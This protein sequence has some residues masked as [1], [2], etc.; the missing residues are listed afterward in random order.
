MASN[1]NKKI[2][3]VS[4]D[5]LPIQLSLL[6]EAD[7]IARPEYNIGKYAGIIFASPHAKNLDRPREHTWKVAKQ[8]RTI[9]ASLT[10]SPQYGRKTPTTTTLRV[11]LGLIQIWNNNGQPRNGEIEFSARQL[12]TAIGWRWGGRD[13]AKRISEHISILKST[14]ITWVFGFKK[15]DGETMTKISELSILASAEYIERELLE[16]K[17]RFTATQKVMFHPTLVENM[18]EG[19]VRPINHETLKQISNDTVLN[20]YARLDVYL[21]SKPKWK[22]NSYD[23]FYDVLKFQG[24]RWEKGFARHAQL[25]KFVAQL[26]HKPLVHGKLRVAI[27]RNV[28][29]T[30]WLLVAWREKTRPSKNRTFLKPIVSDVEA[31]IMADDLLKLIHKHPRPGNPRRAYV[32]FL[33]LHYPRDLILEAISRAKFDYTEVKTNLMAVFQH[34][35]KTLVRSTK[36]LRWHGDVPHEAE[37]GA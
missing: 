14:G 11:Y 36:G 13:T 27:E 31:E 3:T 26:D 33:C 32:M 16:G 12:A 17:E 7:P 4:A 6:G 10:I 23:L 29:D 37:E 19:Y 5:E 28:D 1:D 9:T 20:L 35:L 24:T 25:K 18:I 2:T 34:E 21:S 22:R 8:D 15:Y 30:D